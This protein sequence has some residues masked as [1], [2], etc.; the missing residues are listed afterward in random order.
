MKRGRKTPEKETPEMP[1]PPEH[2]SPWTKLMPA[3]DRPQKEAGFLGKIG[4]L[5]F[6]TLAGAALGATG[7]YCLFFGGRR[8]LTL[9]IPVDM[10]IIKASVAIGAVVGGFLG[11]AAGWTAFRSHGGK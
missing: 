5:I 11:A 8:G 7:G 2:E 4:I 6:F 9:L 10:R 1:L 3:S